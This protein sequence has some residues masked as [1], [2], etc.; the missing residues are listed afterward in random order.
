[1]TGEPK[2]RGPSLQDLL[3]EFGTQIPMREIL[4]AAEPVN[5]DDID[6]IIKERIKKI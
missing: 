5:S 6:P 4:A 3:R 2:D 1:M